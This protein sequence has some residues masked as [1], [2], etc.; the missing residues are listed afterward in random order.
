MSLPPC[1]R[2]ILFLDQTLNGGGAERVLCTVMRGLDPEKYEI[3]LVI[4]TK[5]GALAH[6]IPDHVH[7]HILGIPHT[8][9]AFFATVKAL[10]KIRPDIVYTTTTRTA[11][12]V[13]CSGF[14]S[15]NFILIMRFPMKP[16]SLIHDT[17]A[18]SIKLMRFFFRRADYVIAQTKEMADELTHYF[19]IKRQHI[20]T[21]ANP[22]D[23]E[24]I[25]Q[26]VATAKNPFDRKKIN[27]VASGTVYPVKGYDILLT[28]FAEVVSRNDNY[29]LFIL[30]R[31][32]DGNTEKLQALS[33][34]LSVQNHVHF[35]GFQNN[36]Y[37]YYK[38]CDL[39]VLSSRTEGC[40]N[41]LLEAMYFERPVVAT[42]CVPIIG[43]IV[44]NRETGFLVEPENP[45]Q[46]R[47]AILAYKQL[48]PKKNSKNSN[49]IVE[50]IDQLCCN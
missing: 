33:T 47:D 23:Y 40:P 2:K 41:V 1:R 44:E 49:E 45:E 6:L 10:W 3:H 20:K 15:P 19:E 14:L 13:A 30:G 22:V 8:R 35:L 46:L 5:L 39:F 42:K 24:Q 25:D 27:V 7:V 11:Q 38:F 29:N 32:Q 50:F 4:I 36:P 48:T 9:Q 43:K 26:S 28:A 37:P 16:V 34:E 17:S 21:I 31:D 18:W 12:L